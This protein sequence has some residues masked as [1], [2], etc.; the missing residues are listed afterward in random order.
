MDGRKQVSWIIENLSG[1]VAV[2]TAARR[3]EASLISSFV[4]CRDKLFYSELTLRQDV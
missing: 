4:T 1:T 3:L 2:T